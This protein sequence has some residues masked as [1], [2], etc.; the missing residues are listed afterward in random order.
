M[1]V[2]LFS[3]AGASSRSISVTLASA[4]PTVLQLQLQTQRVPGIAYCASTAYALPVPGGSKW[5]TFTIPLS[6]LSATSAACSGAAALWDQ[7]SVSNPSN[8]PADVYINNIDLV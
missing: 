7:L 8:I 2:F 3:L 6:S 5:T 4:S 1:I